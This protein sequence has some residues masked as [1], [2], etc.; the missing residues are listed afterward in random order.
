[1]EHFLPDTVRVYNKKIKYN[2]FQFIKHFLKT[3]IGDFEY[4]NRVL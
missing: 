4:D 1:M 2:S 3:N